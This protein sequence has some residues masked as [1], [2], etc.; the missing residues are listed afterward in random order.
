MGA[1]DEF[2][3]PGVIE[4]NLAIVDQLGPIADRLN[5]RLSQLAL[6]W[7]CHQ[8]G[9]TGAIAGSRSPEHTRENVGAGDILLEEKDLEEIEGVLAGA[10]GR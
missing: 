1:Y 2:F 9:V 4:K 8:E 3:A 7:V 6:A 10:G 5:V